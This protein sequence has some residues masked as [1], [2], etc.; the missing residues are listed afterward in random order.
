MGLL[1]PIA[2]V[3]VPLLG[4]IVVLYLLKLRR[5][6][7]RV[8]SLVLW[9]SLLRDREANSL[10]QR[11][12]VSPLLL[13]QLL[14]LGLLILAFARP[15]VPSGEAVGQNAV[16]V[17]DV[18]ASMGSRD[19][20]GGPSRLDQA[21]AQ[22]KNIVDALPDG[23]T[24]MLIAS[25]DHATLV[26]PSTDDRSR[27]RSAI[28]GL[29]TQ[30]QQSDMVEA[31]KLAG[32]VASRQANS[33]V[34]LFS[35][36]AFP[37]AGGQVAALPARF[38]FVQVGAT[39]RAEGNQGITA[40][41]LQKGG[42]GLDLFMQVSNSEPV[43]VS[44][45]LDLLADDVPWSARNIEIGPGKTAEVVVPDVPLSARVLQAQLAGSDA[46]AVD[47]VAWVVN[48]ASVPAN[49]LLVT[50]D[51]RFLE[52]SLSLLPTVTLYKVAP[53]DY[54]PGATVNG[55]S[56]DL[57]IFDGG[58]PTST[59]QTL[60]G[61]AIMLFSPQAGNRLVDVSGVV[62]AVVPTAGAGLSDSDQSARDPL[63]RFVD[64][65]GVHVARAQK[66]IL[67]NWAH[68]VVDSDAGP[69]VIAGERDNRNLVVFAFDLHDSDL[70]LQ[71]AFPLLMR[72]LVTYLLPLPAGGLPAA[73]SPGAPVSIS[74]VSDS[75]TSIVLEEP[76]AQEQTWS[77]DTI[78]Q[79]LAYG[80]TS[81]PGVYYVTQYTGD[82]IVAQEAFAVNLFSQAE[83]LTPPNSKPSLPMGA[84]NEPTG[85][86][87]SSTSE[88]IFRRELWPLVALLGI[89]VLLVEWLFAQRIYIRRALT[90]WQTKRAASRLD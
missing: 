31:L 55:V 3:A 69:L 53:K 14:I 2:L 68:A 38:T 66:I 87:N 12:H 24:A 83:S 47:D 28:D 13:L 17:V 46:L 84:Q 77:A 65:S 29:T 5:P 75:V 49:V 78:S 85:A 6:T 86:E 37:A 82:Q 48:R 79:S 39:R 15:W 32:A 30:V 67:P 89:C 52:L 59:L 7:T 10:W 72:N 63:L 62:S 61:G 4:V 26:V 43:S 19:Q 88:G 23:A 25:T 21:K 73:V 8:G 57:T 56:F 42:G 35:D 50:D 22:A 44:R 64:L 1:A 70:P 16:L 54:K 58:V 41:D 90:E 34:W 51:D 76:D 74:R 11:L 60:P 81:S 20:A 40:L 33:A 36:G 71:T 80:G 27:V 18:S 9:S 45:R